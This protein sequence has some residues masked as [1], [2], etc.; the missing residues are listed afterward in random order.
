MFSLNKL[1]DDDIPIPITHI[2]KP[3]RLGKDMTGLELHEFGLALFTSYF[4]NQGCE[5]FAINMNPENGAPHV[6][7]WN[8]QKVLLY[9]WV[10]TDLAPNIPVYVPNETHDFIINLSKQYKA[11]PSFGSITISYASM[12]SNLIPKCGGEYYA[13]LNEFQEI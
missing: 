6:M 11:I 8:Q 13:M 3:E 5:L 2:C 4:S 9:V 7:I 12:E 1:T 10:K